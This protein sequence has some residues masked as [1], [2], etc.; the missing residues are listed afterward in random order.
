LVKKGKGMSSIQLRDGFSVARSLARE[1]IESAVDLRKLFRVIDSDPAIV[2]A[3]VVF[4]DGDFNVVTLREFQ[5]ICSVAVKRVILREAPGHMG[6]Q[7]FHRAL[8]SNTRES[9]LVMDAVSTVAACGGAYLS[10]TVVY[11]G[12][13]VVPVTAGVSLV[14]SA[15]GVVS[16][17]AGSAQCVVGVLRV[18][19]EILDPKGLDKVDSEEWYQTMMAVLDGITLTGAALSMFSIM[20][21]VMV[22]RA[23]TRKTYREILRGLSR[24]ER[25]ALTAEVHKYRKDFIGLPKRYTN[26]QIRQQ[27]YTQLRDLI[28]VGATVGGS[29]ISGNLKPIAVAVYGEF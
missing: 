28:A 29:L 9:K 26:A 3:G 20:R 18:A 4:I 16:A 14:V 25:L 5:P 19:A 17:V 21:H 13:M 24:R 11:G 22:T 6:A 2:G 12:I 27:T 15:I 23:A 10:W 1:H 8:E 7:E